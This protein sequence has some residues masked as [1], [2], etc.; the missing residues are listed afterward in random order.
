MWRGFMTSSMPLER[1]TERDI[2]QSAHC[3]EL[4]ASICTRSTIWRMFSIRGRY[5]P[6][7]I[8]LPLLSCGLNCIVDGAM[9]MPPSPIESSVGGNDD[10]FPTLLIKLV[11]Y[12][13]SVAA[14]AAVMLADCL[15]KTVPGVMERTCCCWRSGRG[16]ASAER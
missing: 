6:G 2:R 10:K 8:S 1:E 15:L 11:R 14:A 7:N 4:P 9:L 12:A 3:Q 5:L 13:A 16:S